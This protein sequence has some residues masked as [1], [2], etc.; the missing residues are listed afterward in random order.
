MS[1]IVLKDSRRSEP[2]SRRPPDYQHGSRSFSTDADDGNEE[3]R[4]RHTERA[5]F[6]ATCTVRLGVRYLTTYSADNL[7]DDRAVHQWVCS[8]H[9]AGGSVHGKQVRA[10]AAP[11]A[12]PGSL[13][14]T[15]CSVFYGIFNSVCT[16]SSSP[17]SPRASGR[18]SVALEREMFPAKRVST[19]GPAS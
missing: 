6:D 15:R 14:L 4:P 3:K 10:G 2:N 16:L 17:T 8:K 18:A 12:L 11:A 13:C 19:N 7:S 1:R 5:S 9:T